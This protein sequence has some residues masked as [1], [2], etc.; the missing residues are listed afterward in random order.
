[1]KK[2]LTDIIRSI[3]KQLLTG[4]KLAICV[5]CLLFIHSASFAQAK[6][7][8]ITGK[9]NSTAGEALVGVTVKVKNAATTTTTDGAGN[10]SITVPDNAI[11][12]ISYVGYKMQEVS[13]SG[14]TALAVSLA[15]EAN[16]GR[17]VRL[18]VSIGSG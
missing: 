16:T 5:T 15:T 18:I 4:L 2:N 13:V 6:D 8:T 9:V 7:V 11:L 12:Q 1:M 3:P 17:K 14:R 10:F